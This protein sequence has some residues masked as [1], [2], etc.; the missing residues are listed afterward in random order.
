MKRVTKGVNYEDYNKGSSARVTGFES[1]GFAVE[2][3]PGRRRFVW[4]V[5]LLQVAALARTNF[6]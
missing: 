4:H 1:I 2:V 6:Q 3:Q 5:R